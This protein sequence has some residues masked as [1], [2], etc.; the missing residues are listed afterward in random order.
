MSE[1]DLQFVIPGV[2]EETLLLDTGLEGPYCGLLPLAGSTTVTTTGLRWNLQD[3]VM[4]FGGLIS[5]SN[6]M[7]AARVT[8]KS[9]LPILWTMSVKE[10]EIDGN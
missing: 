1:R 4:K 9:S 7:A 10:P 3:D 5:T 8:V 2:L 6:E